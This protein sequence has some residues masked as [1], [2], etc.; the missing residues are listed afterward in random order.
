MKINTNKII[1]GLLDNLIW[2]LLLI[3]ISLFSYLTPLY[4]TQQNFTNI[5]VHSA[6]LGVMVVG[7]SFTLLTGNFDLSA[8]STLGLT[9]IIGA[10]L[11]TPAAAPFFGSG[12]M[13][14][15]IVGLAAMFAIGLLIGWI[16]GFLITKLKMNNFIVTLAMLIILRGMVLVWN[17]GESITGMPKSFLAL[18]GGY[19]GPIPISV[20]VM[21][22][23]FLIASFI[24][25]YTRFGRNLYAV[26]GNRDAALASGINPDKR[27]RQVYLISGFLAAFAAWMQLGRIGVAMEQ[28]GKGMIFEIQAAAVIGG[29][30]LFGGRGKMI[31]A[32]GGVLLL[33]S[34]N[35]GL[36]LMRVSGFMINAVRGA[37]ILLAMLIDAQKIRYKSTGD[38]AKSI[39][40][41]EKAKAA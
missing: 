6:V 5:L 20:L 22:I 34:I 40:T 29:I 19:I 24:T 12:W 2:I 25:S 39:S 31:G 35:S 26:G 16:N 13:L 3:S 15:P 41:I 11:I 30:S 21:L 32:L 1:I 18:G 7:Q 17:E 38:N 10:W 4:S 36:N 37:I 14:P 33:A 8:E 28:L 27:I 9:A 23:L